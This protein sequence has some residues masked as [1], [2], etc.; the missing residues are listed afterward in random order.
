MSIKPENLYEK[1]KDS[2]KER[3]EFKYPEGISS[4]SEAMKQDDCFNEV[5]RIT[6]KL[7]LDIDEDTLY[8]TAAK[9][10]KTL[11]PIF[12]KQAEDRFYKF[13]ENR[14]EARKKII[15]EANISIK[16]SEIKTTSTYY[17]AFKTVFAT[18]DGEE[19]EM[20]LEHTFD[21]TLFI[22]YE[23][24]L[25]KL[26][27]Q[28]LDGGEDTRYGIEDGFYVKDE[29]SENVYISLEVPSSWCDFWFEEE[30]SV[31]ER[32]AFE[33]LGLKKEWIRYSGVNG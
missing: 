6:K 5:E 16:Q 8:D 20:D 29:E 18:E 13:V 27:Y 4:H 25:I 7:K 1:I 24:K 11:R 31:F 19:A 28:K 23:D 12:I 3:F 30:E 21:I 9:V 2:I 32:M 14:T 22:K 17:E 26:G 10:K 15:K 33:L